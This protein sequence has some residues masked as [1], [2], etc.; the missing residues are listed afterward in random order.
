MNRHK[1][2]EIGHRGLPFAHPIG[3]SKIDRLIDLLPLRRTHRVLDVGAGKCEFLRRVIRRHGAPATGVEIRGGVAPR[4]R[5]KLRVIVQDAR[6]FA[7][8]RPYEVAACIGSTHALG[9]YLST[10]QTLNRWVARGGFIAV[11][12]G[13]WMKNPARGYLKALDGRREEFGTHEQN[14]ARAEA[15]GL[16]PWWSAT[17]SVDEWDEYEWSYSR[18]IE[19]YAA[20]HPDDPDVEG[21]L[22]HIRSWRRARLKWG[23]D[24]LGFGLYLFRKVS[25][26]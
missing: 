2:S 25:S 26:L 1:L 8:R 22:L 4:S 9:G 18:S 21:M 5:G 16:I 20:N 19:E 23:R 12:E 7:V 17:A 11:G 10:L 24:T 15:M 6:R 3:A 14:I 13:Y